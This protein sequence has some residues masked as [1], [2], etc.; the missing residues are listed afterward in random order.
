M[1]EYQIKTFFHGCVSWLHK[2]DKS[3]TDLRIIIGRK[4]G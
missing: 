4:S 1:T 3:S 2:L